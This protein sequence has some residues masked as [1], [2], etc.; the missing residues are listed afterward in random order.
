[1]S[2]KIYPSVS[3][4]IPTLNSERTLEACLKSIRSQKYSKDVEIIIADGGSIDA[5]LLIA[6]KHKT[7]IIVNK[8]K[9]GEAGKAVGY[10]ASHGEI[11][12]FIDSDNVLPESDWLQKIVMP[13]VDDREIAASEPVYFVYRKNDHW[14]TRYFALLGMGDP[15]N[16]FIGWYDK[17]CYITNKWTGINIKTEDKKDY[18]SFYLEKSIPTIGANGFFVRRSELSKY[19]VRDYL[20]DIDV[21]KALSEKSGVK[22]AKVKIGIIHLFS[23]DINTFI[24]KQKRRIKDYIFFSKHGLRVRDLDSE[25]VYW[26]VV[27]FILSTI[28]IMPLLVQALI[29]YL[30]K[31]DA[32]WLFHP[33]ACWLT[34]F[35]YATETIKSPF[36][37]GIYNREGWRQ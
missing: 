27:K 16:L 8:L 19:P 35:V 18:F 15:V 7:R 21:L 12:G 9:T 20:F 34:L 5:T 30:R 24:R 32:V 37:K 3:I 11:V 14:L 29:G 23:G 1:M 28:F 26:G 13:F 6:K 25:M 4:V 17:Y 33:I 10:K 2:E 22:V 36:I 31:K